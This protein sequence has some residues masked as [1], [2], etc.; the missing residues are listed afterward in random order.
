MLWQL[1]THS[2][3]YPILM[4]HCGST[5][6]RALFDLSCL[7]LL[8]PE[9]FAALMRALGQGA[10]F[11]GCFCSYL[12]GQRYDLAELK[13]LLG[14]LSSAAQHAVY[15]ALTEQGRRTLLRMKQQHR[16]PPGKV[17]ASGAD[18]LQP[19]YEHAARLISPAIGTGI[20]VPCFYGI[21]L[22]L[23]LESKGGLKPLYLMSLALDPGGAPCYQ[24][25][26]ASYPISLT[27]TAQR[28]HNLHAA[29]QQDHVIDSDWPELNQICEI[30]ERPEVSR[31]Q[32]VAALKL[33]NMPQAHVQSNRP[34]FF[35]LG[36]PWGTRLSSKIAASEKV[37]L[38][39]GLKLSCLITTNQIKAVSWALELWL[40]HPI[41]T[42]LLHSFHHESR[43]RYWRRYY[44]EHG[45]KLVTKLGQ[46]QAHLSAL[47]RRLHY[48]AHLTRKKECNP[49][50]SLL[51]P[52][53]SSPYGISKVRLTQLA[54]SKSQLLVLSS[55][56]D[57]DADAVYRTYQHMMQVQS[58]V[59]ICLE[60]GAPRPQLTASE[61]GALAPFV[62]IATVVTA[63]HQT[64]QY[65][66]EEAYIKL[67]AELKQGLAD[68]ESA[69]L[70]FYLQ[71]VP[72]LLAFLAAPQEQRT[73]QG[74]A[75]RIS[76]G[77]Q[78]SEQARH[79]ARQRRLYQLLGVSAWQQL[80][81]D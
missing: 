13:A 7:G 63:L 43:E 67:T 56:L 8:E 79:N 14:A 51:A 30:L 81:P 6:A 52:D 73:P 48:G 2:K 21:K 34:P 20:P 19:D 22:P 68:K 77:Q 64:L 60:A 33:Q 71:D 70:K 25:L 45:T 54:R 58:L 38:E 39:R 74:A 55:C 15:R 16:Y 47:E 40:H 23:Q 11:A 17:F 78:R 24:Y 50:T 76:K 69:A 66:C 28:H 1:A 31:E 53:P 62:F 44:Q 3:L 72:R 4:E 41:S 37:R 29:L 75:G 35:I 26:T 10:E 61:V 80:K 9:R 49:K 65:R 18:P 57:L 5:T 59:R 42:V 36:I 32:L 27:L 12:T 46:A